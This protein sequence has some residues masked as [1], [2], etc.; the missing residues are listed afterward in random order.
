MLLVRQLNTALPLNKESR[1]TQADLQHPI[2]PRIAFEIC[3]NAGRSVSHRRATG[4]ICVL[5]NNV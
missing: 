5:L 4:P 3:C 2:Y 1:N